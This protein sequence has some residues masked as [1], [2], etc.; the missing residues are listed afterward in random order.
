[1]INS[2]FNPNFKYDYIGRDNLFLTINMSFYVPN[3]YGLHRESLNDCSYLMYATAADTAKTKT[4]HIIAIDPNVTYFEN[5]FKNKL[6]PDEK[7]LKFHTVFSNFVI[8]SSSDYSLFYNCKY[9]FLIDNHFS[10]NFYL[11][12]TSKYWYKLQISNINND[13]FY[14]LSIKETSSTGYYNPFTIWTF[15]NKPESFVMLNKNMFKPSINDSDSIKISKDIIPVNYNIKERSTSTKERRLFDF[16]YDNFSNTANVVTGDVF[17]YKTNKNKLDIKGIRYTNDK[18]LIAGLSIG[19]DIN[20]FNTQPE[21]TTKIPGTF[22][23]NTRVIFTKSDFSDWYYIVELNSENY[24]LNGVIRISRSQIKSGTIDKQCLFVK[25]DISNKVTLK[26]VDNLFDDGEL[27][28]LRITKNEYALKKNNNVFSVAHINTPTPLPLRFPPGTDYTLDNLYKPT[29]YINFMI[30]NNICKPLESGIMGTANLK[31]INDD[32]VINITKLNKYFSIA[33]ITFNLTYDQ[34]TNKVS[35][36]S[37]LLNIA[38]FNSTGCYSDKIGILGISPNMTYINTELQ[39]R[40]IPLC[41]AAIQPVEMNYKTGNG[42]IRDTTDCYTKPDDCCFNCKANPKNTVT[43][44]D[45]MRYLRNSLVDTT[46]QYQIKLLLGNDPDIKFDL[47]LVFKQGSDSRFF[48]VTSNNYSINNKF[49]KTSTASSAGTASTAGKIKYSEDPQS[50]INNTPVYKEIIINNGLYTYQPLELNKPIQTNLILIIIFVIV[51]V[52]VLVISI[53]K[54]KSSLNKKRQL[55][56]K[57]ELKY[58]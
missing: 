56:H 29:N 4:S 48:N 32:A 6:N 47:E 53:I 33:D 9:I 8:S 55:L 42:L 34:A 24:V 50:L 12:T 57:L 22:T 23:F 37:N 19:S 54:Y 16:V 10:R 31:L 14:K 36:K 35:I 40:Y 28:G 43:D 11:P 41:D 52:T 30:N 44:M 26:Q 1:M 13:N 39:S 45:F 51:F 15:S 25:K 2:T 27:S 58:N 38:Q 3:V 7:L 46:K 21:F 18:F 49:I 17:I 5:L 20:I